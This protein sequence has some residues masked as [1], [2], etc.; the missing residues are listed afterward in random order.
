MLDPAISRFRRTEVWQLDDDQLV[1]EAGELDT[2]I[3]QLQAAQYARLAEIGSRGI[4]AQRGYGRPEAFLSDLF[5]ISRSEANKRLK[6]ARA[7]HPTPGVTGTPIPA[8]APATAQAAADGAVGPGQ[9]DTV[10][11]VLDRI[12]DTIPVDEREGYE[13]ALADYA[14]V[15]TPASV[16]KLGREVLVRVDPDGTLPRE[17]EL[18][19]PD[20][21]LHMCWTRAGHLA[22]RGRLDRETGQALEAALSPLA[23]P[24]P[25]EDG[26]RDLRAPAE[27]NGD[28]LA[29]IVDLV[30]RED[31]LPTEA[32][33]RPT[34]T[35]VLDYNLLLEGIGSVGVLNG[36]DPITAEQARRIACDSEVI[37]AVLGSNSE[38]LDLGR[39]ERLVSRAQR[40][41]LNLRDRGC[42]FPNCTRPARWTQAHH[43]KTWLDFGPTDLANLCLLCAEHHRLIHHSDWEIVMAADGHPEC[44]PPAYIDPTR[45]PRRNHAH[46]P[47][48]TTRVIHS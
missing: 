44:I 20:R 13:K 31:G 27:R 46:H 34:V 1:A 22:F 41:A 38:V 25:A 29:E 36:T 30:L 40:R 14:R 16:A 32:G 28:A 39:S 6:R 8:V 42:V 21:E 15:A 18:A 33:T 7:L 12:P 37:P 11:D 3:N 47:P 5:T 43:R 17:Q 10:L 35:V 19:Q 4:P 24:R 45:T 48:L 26:T 9:I 23:K 2:L